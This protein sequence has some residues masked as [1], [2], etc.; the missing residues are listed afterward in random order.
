[1]ATQLFKGQHSQYFPA[2]RVQ[3]MLKRGW[4]VEPENDQREA[5]LRAEA[6]ELG[7]SHWW[8]KSMATLETEIYRLKSVDMV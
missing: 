2:E 5:E 3:A 7:I 8:T 6:K 4:T 1:M